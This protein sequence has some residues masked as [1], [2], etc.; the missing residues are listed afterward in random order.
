MR[1]HPEA[2]QVVLGSLLSHRYSHVCPSQGGGSPLSPEEASE[3][4]ASTFSVPMMLRGFSSFVGSLGNVIAD[5]L[6]LK[7]S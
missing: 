3:R 1:L 5:Q 6:P 7:E 4:P 2:A